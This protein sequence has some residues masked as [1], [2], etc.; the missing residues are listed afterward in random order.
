MTAGWPNSLSEPGMDLAWICF[1]LIKPNKCQ[2]QIQIKSTLFN[3]SQ[4][5]IRI[6]EAK[7]GLKSDSNQIR[8]CTPLRQFFNFFWLGKDVIGLAETG[9]GK[10]AAFA[11][12]ILQSL[13]G[14]CLYTCIVARWRT[15]VSSKLPKGYNDKSYM[16]NH[17]LMY[18]TLVAYH[19]NLQTN[20]L[21]ESGQPFYSRSTVLNAD[22][23]KLFD[24]L[25]CLGS[26]PCYWKQPPYNLGPKRTASHMNII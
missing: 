3:I 9:S 18:M 12:P 1:F 21:V 13:L 23:L 17:V 25:R 7:S 20:K 26:G 16:V 15:W 8:I 22:V 24:R 5:Q 14:R 6:H 4:I 11:L 2:T 19:I 10:T